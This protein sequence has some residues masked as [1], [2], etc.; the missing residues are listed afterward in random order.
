[1]VRALFLIIFFIAF[2]IFVV[3]KFVATG[4]KTAYD[5]V[6]NPE[7]AEAKLFLVEAHSYIGQFLA[8]NGADTY[9]LR[10]ALPQVI[11]PVANMARRHGFFLSPEVIKGIVAKSVAAH[12]TAPEYDVLKMLG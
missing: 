10:S 2:A 3:I 12:G 1:M 6:F 4:V 8:T 11:Q 7:K 9:R 5:A